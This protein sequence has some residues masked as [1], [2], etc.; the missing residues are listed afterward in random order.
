MEVIWVSFS[1]LIEKELRQQRNKLKDSGRILERA[2]E[3]FLKM[4]ERKD[5]AVF[6]RKHK[7]ESGYLEE[8]L[9]KN[10]QMV[11]K[12]LD[13]RIMQEV[14]RRAEKNII[15]LEDLQSGY[16][17]IAQRD[18]LHELSPAYQ[19]AFS[20]FTEKELS[21]WANADYPKCEYEPQH[22][23]H[24]TLNGVLVRSKSEVIIANTMTYYHIPFHYEERLE[25]AGQPGKYFYPDFHIKLPSGEFKIWE[26]LGL[27]SK[28]SYCENTANKLY[29]Y[30]MNGF[31]I[32]KD[33]ILTQDDNKGSCNSAW[34]DEVVRTQFL[35]H[36]L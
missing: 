6:Y 27:L 9:S 20:R 17:S 23:V 12:L 4:R 32:G 2:P 29:T 1:F 16:Q 8:N 14:N 18:I 34:I 31:V 28:I 13:K 15:L 11:R 36:F 22:L 24:E 30:Q 33:L 10:P 26:H 7:T 25:F 35:P 3:G 21:D 5:E 19:R